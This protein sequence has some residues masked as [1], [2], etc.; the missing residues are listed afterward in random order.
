MSTIENAV[1]QYE[2]SKAKLFNDAGKP[3]YS[4]AEHAKRLASLQSDL[5]AAM[6]NVISAAE[7]RIAETQAKITALEAK[8]ALDALSP[9]ELL[10]ANERGAFIKEDI[11]SMA[12]SDLVIRLKALLADGKDKVALFL[13]SRYVP[14]RHAA[15]SKKPNSPQQNAALRELRELIG[16]AEAKLNPSQEATIKQLRDSI[17]SAHLEQMKAR[18][19][20]HASHTQPSQTLVRL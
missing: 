3:I 10:A 20:M 17:Q 2:N 5:Q 9:S 16:Q 8:S 13:Y 7:A 4:E 6:D 12:V 11:D 19:A 15:E 14:A 18:Q 1:Q